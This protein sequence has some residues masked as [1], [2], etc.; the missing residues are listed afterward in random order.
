MLLLAF[1]LWKN[2]Q[3]KSEVEHLRREVSTM[4]D[5]LQAQARRATSDASA[6]RELAAEVTQLRADALRTASVAPPMPAMSARQDDPAESRPEASSRVVSPEEVTQHIETT[7]EGEAMDT[8]WARGV[9]QGLQ[10]KLAPLLSKGSSIGSLECH[11]SLCRI[12][13][14][15]PDEEQY[16]QFMQRMTQGGT[17]WKG[18]SM[19]YR[20]EEDGRDIVTISYLAREGHAMPFPETARSTHP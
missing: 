6:A 2:S 17:F 7:F 11:T 19:T 14:R 20:S 5:A 3:Y 16:Q 9:R 1:T 13:L 10:E 4:S 8:A 15:H 18:A 12:E